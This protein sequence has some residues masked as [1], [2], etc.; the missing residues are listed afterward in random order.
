MAFQIADDRAPFGL[1][2]ARTAVNLA[3]LSHKWVRILTSALIFRREARAAKTGRFAARA[4]SA[5]WHAPG[6]ADE[7]SSA[8][9]LEGVKHGDECPAVLG[10]PQPST[11]AREG[12]AL[13]GLAL[14]A[15]PL[16]A[17]DQA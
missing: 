5:N 1:S 13:S 2:T 15:A 9:L 10:T 12:Q 3:T 8:L 17:R 11:R 14:M 4:G 7:V 6:L 16:E